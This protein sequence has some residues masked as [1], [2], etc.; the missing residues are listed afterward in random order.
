M[1]V[2]GGRGDGQQGQP[3]VEV[4][5]ETERCLLSL[6]T[7]RALKPPWNDGSKVRLQ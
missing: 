6:V 5:Q 4:K 3:S 1:A 2:V 7:K